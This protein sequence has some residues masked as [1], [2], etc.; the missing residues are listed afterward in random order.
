MKNSKI[1]SVKS[2]YKN[3]EQFKILHRILWVLI[4]LVVF[5]LSWIFYDRPSV[6]AHIQIPIPIRFLYRKS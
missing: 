3:S 2:E 6:M 5:N 4:Y 1:L